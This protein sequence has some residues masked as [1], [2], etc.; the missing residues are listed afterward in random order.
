M[1]DIRCP[2]CGRP[3]PAN[4][5]VCQFCQARLKPLVIS[6]SSGEEKPGKSSG[7]PAPIQPEEPD[8]IP[9]WLRDLRQKDDVEAE[10]ASQPQ[11]STDDSLPAWLMKTRKIPPQAQRLALVIL[12][13]G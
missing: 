13:T 11:E 4:Q 6:P 9:D 8:S 10:P 7:G 3:N 5:E 2:M 12:P 1:A